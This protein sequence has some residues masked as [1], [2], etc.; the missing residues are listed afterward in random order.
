MA[1]PT[2][3]GFEQKRRIGMI[4]D[5]AGRRRIEESEGLKRLTR[6]IRALADQRA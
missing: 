5:P 2:L 1:M 3:I 6:T 4:T